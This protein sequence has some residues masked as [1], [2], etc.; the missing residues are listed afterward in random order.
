[1]K[2][3]GSEASALRSRPRCRSTA[4]M[5]STRRSTGSGRR[6]H[7]CRSARHSRSTTCR[8]QHGSGP[9][10]TA[11]WVRAPMPVELVM[12]KL[13][14]TM[15]EGTLSQW[16]VDDGA[17]VVADQPVFCLTTEKVDT[18]VEA[19]EAGTVRQVVPAGTTVATGTVVGW[20]VGAGEDVAVPA[21]SAA[22]AAP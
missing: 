3:F 1:M 11:C 15:K 10:Y 9:R 5:S 17:A 13:G 16:L 12:P 8:T 20:I 14:M 2:R 4:S 21:V 7:R 22:P 19:P 18:E 6:S